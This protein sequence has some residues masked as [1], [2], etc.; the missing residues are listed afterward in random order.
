MGF[1]TKSVKSLFI[2][3]IDITNINITNIIL[4]NSNIELY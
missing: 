1:K 4:N 2:L 3:Y